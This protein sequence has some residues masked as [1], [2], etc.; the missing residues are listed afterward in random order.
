MLPST[1][2]TTV[3]AIA[4]AG[5]A[6]VLCR[7]PA[8]ASRVEAAAAALTNWR[9]W[10]STLLFGGPMLALLHSLQPVAIAAALV[11]GLLGTV[12][13]A[14]SASR[15]VQQAGAKRAKDV[16]DNRSQR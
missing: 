2:P 7:P 9:G 10:L 4:L 14:A 16:T 6:A 12:L 3:A 1:P 11:A 13:T 5:L 8:G 15:A